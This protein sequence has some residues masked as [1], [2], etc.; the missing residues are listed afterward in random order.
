[1]ESIKIIR[2]CNGQN[3]CILASVEA[4][5]MKQKGATI[6]KKCNG[7]RN[8]LRGGYAMRYLDGVPA[9]AKKQYW[10]Q[11]PWNTF[12]LLLQRA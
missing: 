7:F 6:M 1:M 5:Y 2:L 10:N 9:A 11:S 4:H 8:I 3:Q 12:R